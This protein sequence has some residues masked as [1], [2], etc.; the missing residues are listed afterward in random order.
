MSI[1]WANIGIPV[2][3][4]VLSFASFVVS[5]FALY[6][7][8]RWRGK[9][10]FAL[11][12]EPVDEGIV[13]QVVESSSGLMPARLLRI[14]SVG[15]V[16]PLRVETRGRFCRATMFLRDADD[17]IK[18]MGQITG[19]QLDEGTV[20]V[21]VFPP[22]YI[23][24]LSDQA[25]VILHWYEPPQRAHRH[26][27]K[28]FSPYVSRMTAKRNPLVRGFGSVVRWMT[29]RRLH[30]R[31]HHWSED[32]LATEGAPVPSDAHHSFSQAGPG[33][34]KGISTPVR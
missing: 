4:V 21:A 31:F 13:R 23:G 18:P 8:H 34:I 6:S 17:A 28:A 10:D 20:F 27:M 24:H 33:P 1:D 19:R 12:D 22:D 11:F 14:G 15:D 5:A 7:T 16:H 29:D 32:R 30:W 25:R 3:A 26:A 2:I 9:P